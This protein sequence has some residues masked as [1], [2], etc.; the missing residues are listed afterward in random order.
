MTDALS[1]D[2]LDQE[3]YG[4]C[5]GSSVRHVKDSEPGIVIEID[6]DADLGEVTTCRV[7]WGAQSLQD[8]LAT[9]R[10]DSDI[11]WTTKLL[12]A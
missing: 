8:A 10:E 7:V 2:Q 9:P 11:Q 4:F 3:R 6:S 5:V 12:A 1:K